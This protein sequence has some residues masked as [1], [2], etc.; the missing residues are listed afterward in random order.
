MT[1]HSSLR[2]DSECW[3]AGPRGVC[4]LPEGLFLY[5]ARVKYLQIS[6][7]FFVLTCLKF[8]MGKGLLY[9]SVSKS[10]W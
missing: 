7:T 2:S 8:Q 1:G 6:F 3:T 9:Q 10:V 5:Q 4:W